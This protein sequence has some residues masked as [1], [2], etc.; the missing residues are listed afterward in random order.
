MLGVSPWRL[1]LKQSPSAVL[2]AVLLCLVV[3]PGM[4]V[5]LAQGN[6]WTKPFMVSDP[7]KTPS[8]WFPDLAI[9][10]DGSVHIIWGSG[11]AGA[12]KEDPG[13]DL[14][15]YREQHDGTWSSI[16]D[17]DNTGKGGYTVRNSIAMGHDGNL[18]V[19]VR[20][21]LITTFLSAPWQK[22]WSAQAWSDPH[23]INNGTSYF[24]ALATDS[25]GAIH[26][27]WNEAIIDDPNAPK[28]ACANCA[29][30]FYRSSSDGGK[31]WSSPFNLSQS[32]Q[33][34]VKQQIKIDQDNHLHVVWEEGFD[35]YASQ[36]T[37]EAGE[38]R[39][40]RDGGKSWDAPVRFSLPNLVPKPPP[41]SSQP[42]AT[43]QPTPAPL[44]DAP[45][46]LTLGLFQNRAPIVVYRGNVSD[47]IYYQSSADDGTTW[48][49]VAAIPGIRARDIR[50]TDH[51]SYAMVTDGAGNVHLVCSGMLANATDEDPPLQL[52][53]L[54]W[55][56][57]KW[58]APEIIATSTDYPEVDQVT[59][60]DGKRVLVYP[61][62]AR[63][64]VSGNTL[65]VTWFTRNKRDL[66]TSD[67]ARYQV[68]YSTL[69]LSGAPLDAIAQFT[70]VPTSLPATPTP[71]P[72]EV[73]VPTLD[74]VSANAPPINHAVAWEGP[75][76]VAMGGALLA[77]TVLLAASIG[78][79]R[80]LWQ[81]RSTRHARR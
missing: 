34:S 56:G 11:L 50:Q 74:P 4:H 48:S 21:G 57:Q 46:Q 61:E 64:A 12:K 79:Y 54:V 39:R 53:H 9:G 23:P 52:F 18:A 47:N 73:V 19:L 76:V 36:G 42:D 6:G 14:L 70:P 10:P 20:Q 24:N 62:W 2:V 45:R 67:N 49:K 38:Y 81:R 32:P 26:A 75:A 65:H 30:L 28:P 58:S 8:S 1:L 80:L 35:W 7:A 15:M 60:I 37:P 59:R 41:S 5:A 43:P 16:N 77:V 72:T 13:L 33:G 31:T 51:D 27:V 66:Y 68:W 44:P 69:T 25:T 22:A 40:S 78:M 17:I 29:D 55:N 3:A 63:A 71:L